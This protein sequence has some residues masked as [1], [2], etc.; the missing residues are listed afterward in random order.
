[1]S[2]PGNLPQKSKMSRQLSN[3]LEDM[4]QNELVELAL[5][6]SRKAYPFEGLTSSEVKLL[7]DA[8][9]G[10]NENIQNN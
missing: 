10:Q 4:T 9:K 5:I 7:S 3:G 2:I 1:M 8:L 6:L